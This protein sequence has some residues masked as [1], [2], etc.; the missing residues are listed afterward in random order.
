LR[1]VPHLGWRCRSARKA[2]SRAWWRS[3]RV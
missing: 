3:R 2:W 1:S